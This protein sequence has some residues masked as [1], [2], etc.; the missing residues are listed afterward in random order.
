[1]I[2]DERSEMTNGYSTNKKLKWEVV[3]PLSSSKASRIVSGI[4]GTMLKLICVDCNNYDT[5]KIDYIR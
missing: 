5:L 4:S 1:M 2:T 3:Q